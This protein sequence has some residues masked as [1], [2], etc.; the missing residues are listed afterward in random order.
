[1]QTGTLPLSGQLAVL[2]LGPPIMA[3][4]WWMLGTVWSHV[5]QGGNPTPR[6]KVWA[7]KGFW[8]LLVT[9]YAI[10]IGM[11]IYVWVLTP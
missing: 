3:A 10:A 11:A 7:S 1:M 2:L 8:I 9:M 5:A 6:T 4:L